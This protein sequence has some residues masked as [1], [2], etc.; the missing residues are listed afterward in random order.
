MILLRLNIIWKKKKNIKRYE[1]QEAKHNL[2]ISQEEG[3][4][5]KIRWKFDYILERER[6][7]ERSN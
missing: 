6:E 1:T 2:L 4:A 7:K 3:K 5:M